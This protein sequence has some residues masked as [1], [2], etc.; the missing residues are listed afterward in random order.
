MTKL[1]FASLLFCCLFAN[2]QDPANSSLAFAHVTVIDVSSGRLEPDQTVVVAGERIA[3]VG[4]TGKVT[5]PRSARIV[6]ARNKFLIP[7]LWDMHVHGTGIDNFSKLYIANGV[8]GIRDMFTL[9]DQIQAER[10]QIRNGQPGPRI[11][12]AGRIVDG[13]KPIWRDSVAVKDAEE[14]RRAVETVKREGSD[15]V[16]VY[17]LLPR[18]AYFAIAAEAKRQGMDFVGHVPQAVTAAEASDAGQKSIE[19][20]TG[21]LRGCSPHEDEVMHR[22]GPAIPGKQRIM[23]D[24]RMILDSYDEKRAQALFARFKRNHTWQ[25]PTLTVLYNFGH[26]YDGS[27][28]NDWRLKY[29]PHEELAYWRPEND[30]RFGK[31]PEGWEK[32]MQQIYGKEVELV[33][34]MR[35]AGVEFLAGTD[36]LNPFCFPGFSLHD[37]LGRLVGAGLTPLEALQTATINPA[38]FLGREK[39]LGTI[40]PGK[41]ADVVLLDANP[42]QDIGNTKTIRAVVAN[43]RCYNRA[44]LDGFLAEAEKAGR[45]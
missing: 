29:L 9:M 38:R 34:K 22:D 20:L 4:K 2:A 40:E 30:F 15:F 17:E 43:G 42:L 26:V 12:A 33:G 18:D 39:E 23:A 19:H 6:E 5:L 10:V 32:T 1:L 41:L 13:P 36:T 16:K 45:R 25:C 31:A 14:G 21:I 28:T 3:E 37:E 27:L 7:G 11:V 24:A 35:R 44:M 8:T